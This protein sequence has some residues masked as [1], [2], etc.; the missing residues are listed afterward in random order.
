MPRVVDKKND[1]RNLTNK[2]RYAASGRGLIACVKDAARKQDM[3]LGLPS[4]DPL[5]ARLR[6][7]RA[8]AGESVER[9]DIPLDPPEAPGEFGEGGERLFDPSEGR[10]E[11]PGRLARVSPGPPD[12]R[13]RVQGKWRTI[14][15]L[16]VWGMWSFPHA[17]RSGAGSGAAPQRTHGT[18]YRP[19]DD[20]AGRLVSRGPCA[21]VRQ[22]PVDRRCESD[23]CVRM[24]GAVQLLRRKADEECHLHQT[25]SIGPERTFASPLA[26]AVQ[27][28]ENGHS[29]RVSP[30][31]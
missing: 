12:G 23:S 5:I 21:P 17:A 7:D 27:L 24:E 19:K 31:Y 15:A 22:R 3:R 16:G 28:Y 1:A 14:P 25:S 30:I 6:A 26:A 4:R 11:G 18:R 8:G 29:L 10:Q 9:G 2:P 13:L 20:C